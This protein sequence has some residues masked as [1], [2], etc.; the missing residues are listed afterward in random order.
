MYLIVRE[1]RKVGDRQT[2][3]LFLDDTVIWK[4]VIRK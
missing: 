2:R 3:A 1:V 4:A